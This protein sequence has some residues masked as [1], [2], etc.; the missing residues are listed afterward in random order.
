MT[1]KV[2]CNEGPVE[3]N[4]IAVRPLDIDKAKIFS[5]HGKS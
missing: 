1:V 2:I 5:I 4:A 3:S